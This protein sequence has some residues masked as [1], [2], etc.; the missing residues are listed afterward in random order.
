MEIFITHE[1]A[2][3]AMPAATGISLALPSCFCH[4]LSYGLSALLLHLAYYQPGSRN[5]TPL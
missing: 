3:E 2:D 4:Q 1:I 5:C